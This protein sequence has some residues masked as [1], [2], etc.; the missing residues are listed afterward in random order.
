MTVALHALIKHIFDD[1]L[2]LSLN[3]I[4]TLDHE[5][6]LGLS[7]LKCSGSLFKRTFQKRKKVYEEYEQTTRYLYEVWS[8]HKL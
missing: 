6:R 4:Q 1:L 8:C 7:Y 3:L 2:Q 5:R